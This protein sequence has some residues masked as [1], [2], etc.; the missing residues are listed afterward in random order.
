MPQWDNQDNTVSP[1][2]PLPIILSPATPEG[3]HRVLFILS[4]TEA[5]TAFSSKNPNLLQPKAHYSVTTT[6]QNRSRILKRL[7]SETTSFFKTEVDGAHK[8]CDTDHSLLSPYV[9]L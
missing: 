6:T 2:M 3:T 9:Q 5:F 7:I 8:D 1:D 4:E